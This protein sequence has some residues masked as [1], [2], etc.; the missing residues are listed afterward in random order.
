M[1]DRLLRVHIQS[2]RAFGP[3]WTLSYNNVL[4]MMLSNASLMG[5]LACMWVTQHLYRRLHA[6]LPSKAQWAGRVDVLGIV[7]PPFVGCPCPSDITVPANFSFLRC[8]AQVGLEGKDMPQQQVNLSNDAT[9]RSGLSA[10]PN[11]GAG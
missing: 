7:S 6:R 3:Q 10:L 4:N 9:P 11:A 5:Q 1:V 8:L 2:Q